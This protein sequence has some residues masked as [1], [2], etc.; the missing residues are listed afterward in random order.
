MIRGW[1]M[2]KSYGVEV[3]ALIDKLARAAKAPDVV[4]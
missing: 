4:A 2:C 1:V 3:A